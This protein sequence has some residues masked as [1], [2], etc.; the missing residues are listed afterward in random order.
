MAN[1]QIVHFQTRQYQSIILERHG[2][3][4]EVLE[5][6]NFRLIFGS[7]LSIWTVRRFAVLILI[8]NTVAVDCKA[9]LGKMVVKSCQPNC[10]Y[11]VYCMLVNDQC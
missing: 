11:V 9:R 2:H 5:L 4:L 7:L 3:L 6:F 8:L 10:T 1:F